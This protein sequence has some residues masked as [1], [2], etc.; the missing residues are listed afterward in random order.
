MFPGQFIRLDL[1]QD[2]FWDNKLFFR[3]IP[4]RFPHRFDDLFLFEQAPQPFLIGWG[5][6]ATRLTRGKPLGKA[7]LVDRAD[8]AVDPAEA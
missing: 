2:I 7:L 8:D 4:Q 5:I 3:E 6:L 1:C